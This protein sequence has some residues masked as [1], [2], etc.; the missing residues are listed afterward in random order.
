MKRLLPVLGLLFSLHCPSSLYGQSSETT[1][2]D[3]VEWGLTIA[4]LEWKGGYT[5]LPP[6]KQK[7]P[8]P[9]NCGKLDVMLLF[10]NTGSMAS[11]IQQ[12][13]YE[14]TGLLLKIQERYEDS[15]FAVATVGDF[16][17]RGGSF[18][19][20]Y[21]FVSGFTPGLNETVVAIDSIRLGS[22]GDFEEAY[23]YALRMASN[24]DW[25]PD[26]YR[27]VVLI[28]DSTARDDYALYRS[29]QKSNF[30]LVTLATDESIL[31]YW[32]QVSKIAMEL[33]EGEQM[34]EAL[35]ELVVKGCG[36]SL[37]VQA[38]PNQEYEREQD[39]TRLERTVF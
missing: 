8:A 5:A 35:F 11:D 36:E 21:E 18:D 4:E 2:P 14:G 37:M 3:K 20:P 25:R 13:R 34:A 32:K 1:S 23:P 15:R 33:P 24:E 7:L 28:A 10:D 39:H 12:A 9:K 22:G 38:F 19:K 6:L 17:E 30:N 27:L 29:V 16:P 26:A 31:D